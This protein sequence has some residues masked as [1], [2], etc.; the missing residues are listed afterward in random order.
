MKKITFMVQGSSAQPYEV[1]FT[2]GEDAPVA[3]CSCKAALMGQICKH[4]IRIIEGN[5]EGVIS[6]NID[7]IPIVLDWVFGSSLAETLAVL[8]IAETELEQA[9]KRVTEAKKNVSSAMRP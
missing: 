5:S 8:A 9:K 1:I 2:K 3:T 4:R 6:E 7:E